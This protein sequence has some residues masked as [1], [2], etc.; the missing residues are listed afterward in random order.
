LFIV[1]S[2]GSTGAGE[3]IPVPEPLTLKGSHG[4]KDIES[5]INSHNDNNDDDD[6]DDGSINDS[7]I[8]EIDHDSKDDDI[9][10]KKSE[11][12]IKNDNIMDSNA[13]GDD[14][15]SSTGSSEEDERVKK[16]LANWE[17]DD[18]EEEI[19][20]IAKDQV[21]EELQVITE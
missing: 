16:M 10:C 11:K 9:L 20:D 7:V 8:S 6:S 2:L 19:E 15:E 17:A 5:N 13:T 14:N 21:V 12:N 18:H 1:F 4:R 3:P